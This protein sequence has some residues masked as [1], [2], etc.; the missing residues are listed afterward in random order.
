M[1]LPFPSTL[2]LSSPTSFYRQQTVSSARVPGWLGLCSL[3]LTN[4]EHLPLQCRWG[5][6]DFPLPFGRTMTAAEERIHEMD[7]K[8]SWWGVHSRSNMQLHERH[9]Q[10]GG[11]LLSPLR[12]L[13]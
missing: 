10:Q 12:L 8:V 11:V 4:C 2:T 3:S 5:N 9:H 7:E 6:L 1:W 13:Q